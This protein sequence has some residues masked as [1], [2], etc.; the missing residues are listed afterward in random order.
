MSDPR[1]TPT[2][3]QR[4][5]VSKIVGPGHADSRRKGADA[6]AKVQANADRVAAMN[7]DRDR[8]TDLASPKP[9]TREACITYL[10]GAGAY[11]GH[12]RDS[13]DQ[14]RAEVARI[15]GLVPAAERTIPSPTEAEL[16]R[17]AA[18]VEG[19]ERDV[20]CADLQP[21]AGRV[22]RTALA[23]AEW[24]QLR[25]WRTSDLV[26]RGPRPCTPNLDALNADNAGAQQ[27]SRQRTTAARTSTPRPAASPAYAAAMAA[28]KAGKRGAG[29]KVTD[30]ELVAYIA[31]A[32]QERPDATGNQ[33]LEVAYWVA[34]LA[35]TRS[36]WN[37]AWAEVVAAAA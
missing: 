15:K 30:A 4:S 26:G 12:S 27:G 2:N 36:R 35:I 34:K 28:K 3:R 22:E 32:R 24:T 31:Q 10:Q 9:M 19:E 17:V 16:A 6:R 8:A 11:T 5:Q 37:A 14:L 21:A 13:V 25:A 18:D 33:E 20:A 1:N 29:T 23:E 7:A